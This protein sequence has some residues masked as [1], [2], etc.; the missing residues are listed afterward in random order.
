MTPTPPIRAQIEAERLYQQQMQ[1]AQRLAEQQAQQAAQGH[2]AS[3][4]QQAGSAA[5][6]RR[7]SLPPAGHRQRAHGLTKQLLQ[8]EWQHQPAAADGAEA[9]DLSNRAL[10]Q[11]IWA[12]ED[13]TAAAENTSRR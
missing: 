4:Q 8:L 12:I 3:A 2:S 5:R 7:S 6:R 10:Q 11:R 9:L 13:E 1:E